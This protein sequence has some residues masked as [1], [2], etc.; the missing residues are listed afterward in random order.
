MVFNF[1]KTKE[2]VK[3]CVKTKHSQI[4]KIY[5]ELRIIEDR[6][7]WKRIEY[8]NKYE[9]F[10]KNSKL[11]FLQFIKANFDITCHMYTQTK[12]YVE[13]QEED[14]D[15]YLFISKYGI[16]RT[17]TLFN[18]P[19]IRQQIIENADKLGDSADFNEIVIGINGKSPAK[20][21]KCT[22]KCKAELKNLRKLYKEKVV[23]LNTA[24]EAVQNVYERLQT[25]IEKYKVDTFSL[26]EE[27]RSK[28]NEIQKLK[29]N[30]YTHQQ[31]IPFDTVPFPVI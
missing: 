19:D 27:I 31:K 13:Y 8:Y 29:K 6:K 10:E 20:S 14:W 23:E 22:S 26:K 16:K 30:N 18:N 12:I 28:E 25:Q 1:E 17:R 2:F 7:W 21:K 9:D 15:G 11:T 24:H 5:E 3:K 4:L